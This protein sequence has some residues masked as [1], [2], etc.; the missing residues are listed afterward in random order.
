MGNPQLPLASANDLLSGTVK[1][2]Q[3]SLRKEESQKITEKSND[4][5]SGINIF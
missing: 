4:I 3:Q 1:P 2:N 5:R